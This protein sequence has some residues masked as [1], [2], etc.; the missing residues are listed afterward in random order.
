MVYNIHSY[1]QL[2][3]EPKTGPFVLFFPLLCNDLDKRTFGAAIANVVT[4]GRLPQVASTE[5]NIALAPVLLKYIATVLPIF[6][7]RAL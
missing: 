1:K 4:G 5:Y 7:K 3:D 2:P 6:P